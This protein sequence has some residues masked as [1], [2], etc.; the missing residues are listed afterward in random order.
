[1]QQVENKTQKLSILKGVKYFIGPKLLHRLFEKKFI[2]NSS[3]D[4]TALI[5]EGECLSF[6]NR[7]VSYRIAENFQ[8]KVCRDVRQ[9]TW[10]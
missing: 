3:N 7:N 6:R 2:K 1:M 8:T 10:S 5:Y 4:E 9:N